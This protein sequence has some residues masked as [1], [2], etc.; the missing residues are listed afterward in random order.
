MINLRF[1]PADI[2]PDLVVLDFEQGECPDRL[3]AAGAHQVVDS[4]AGAADL[5]GR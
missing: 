5:I 4:Y 2:K 3:R 1:P